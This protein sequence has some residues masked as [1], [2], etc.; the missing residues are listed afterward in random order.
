MHLLMYLVFI[1]ILGLLSAIPEIIGAI[2]HP[3][4][5]W[6]YDDEDTYLL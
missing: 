1:L 2:K 5:K 6:Q 3:D 4:P